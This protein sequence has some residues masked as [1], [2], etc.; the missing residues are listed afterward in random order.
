[1]L[2]EAG[3]PAALNPLTHEGY[4]RTR[5]FPA[6]DGLR[7]L[8]VLMVLVYHCPRLPLPGVPQVQMAGDTGVDVFF[9]LSGFLIT[10]LLLRDRRG[11]GASTQSLLGQFYIKRVLRIFPLYYLAI[12]LYWLKVHV[13]PDPLA[14][15]L[16]NDF[17]P[18]ISTYTI[19][20]ALGWGHGGFPAFGIAWSLGVEEKFYLL[21]P[22]VVL[23]LRPRHVL[24]AGPGRHWRDAA[25]A[26][27]AR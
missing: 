1:M 10:M 21:W 18:Y 15:G 23:L 11:T 27:V 26:G 2:N 12:G 24:Y 14:V 20:A 8:A 6:L 13:S 19:D 5:Y 7:G 9:V 25:V 22:F 17:L 16:Y 4:E 3:K